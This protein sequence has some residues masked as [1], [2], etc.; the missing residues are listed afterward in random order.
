M[1]TLSPLKIGFSIYIRQAL[2]TVTPMTNIATPRCAKLIPYAD[3]GK[4]KDLC[5]KVVKDN[6]IPTF[7]INSYIVPRNNQKPRNTPKNAEAE[8][9]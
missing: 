6:F 9:S 3:L 1:L 4:F 8:P 7:S 5:I 2:E